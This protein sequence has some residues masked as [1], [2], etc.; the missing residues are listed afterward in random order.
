MLHQLI[1][2]VSSMISLYNSF[3]IITIKS[4][5]PSSLNLIKVLFRQCG[6]TQGEPIYK[7]FLPLFPTF[8][9]IFSSAQNA[10]STEVIQDLLIEL[11]LSLPA[12]LS[13]LIPFMPLL[14]DPAINS[15]QN[16]NIWFNP[17]GL[18]TI[19]LCLD[20]YTATQIK[21]FFGNNFQR[22]HEH[23]WNMVSHNDQSFAQQAVRL[24]GK[25]SAMNRNILCD[26]QKLQYDEDVNDE[27][28]KLSIRFERCGRR[29]DAVFMDY[30]LTGQ[31]DG[32]VPEYP[33]P[34]F[35]ERMVGIGLEYS[36][37]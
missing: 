21:E 7:L 32:Q 30:L 3:I 36:F 1:S 34:Q 23:L 2:S 35:F 14:V 16:F 20:N 15:L 25:L 17:Q 4:S 5:A 9:Q 11:C 12:R 18:R 28:I 24:I 8:L 31:P 13:S 33:D 22:L 27:S 37:K 29:P 10:F 6:M 19:E 26:T